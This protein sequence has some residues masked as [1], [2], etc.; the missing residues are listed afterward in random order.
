MTK[1]GTGAEVLAGSMIEIHYVAMAQATGEVF[2]STWDRGQ[3]VRI[4][5]GAGQALPAWDDGLIGKSE[6]DTVRFVI[7]Q[8]EGIDPAFADSTIITEVTIVRIVS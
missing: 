4:E 2:D 3:S 6:G 5:V 8:V 7:P 1:E